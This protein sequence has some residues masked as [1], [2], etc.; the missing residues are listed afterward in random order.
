MGANDGCDAVS[1][2]VTILK[3]RKAGGRA[4]KRHAWYPDI[5]KFKSDDYDAGHSFDHSRAVVTDIASLG[6]LVD[7]IRTDPLC[8]IIRGELK[9]GHGEKGA[10]VARRY[11]KGTN[12]PFED[13]P[14]RWLMAD[15]DNWQIPA[16]LDLVEDT[17][18]IIERAISELLPE[19]FHDCR[20]FWQLS[21]SAGI[22]P[23]LRAHVWY[24]LDRPVPT[25][26]LKAWMEANARGIDQKL[27]NAVQIH[28]CTDPIIVGAP[29]PVP[30]R[31][32]WVQG[33]RD[34]VTMPEMNVGA[35]RTKRS[36]QSYSNASSGG[37]SPSQAAT[38][39]GALAEMGDD[40]GLKG[41]HGPILRAG[42]LY[43]RATPP[44]QR[45]PGALKPKI[46]EAIQA[47][48]KGPQRG[49]DI[50]RYMSDD[51]LD[52]TIVGAFALVPKVDG[53][54][55]CEP[56]HRLPT[57]D[58]EVARARMGDII[59]GFVAKPTRPPML[60]LPSDPVPRRAMV[61]SEVGLGKTQAALEAIADFIKAAKEEGRPHRVIFAIP[62]HILGVAVLARARALGIDA[63]TWHG[64]QYVSPDTGPMCSDYEAVKLAEE[65]SVDAN[66]TVCG[67]ITSDARCRF[68]FTCPYQAQRAPA[69]SA[70]LIVMAHNLLFHRLN[71]EIKGGVGLVVI[72]ESFWQA[73]LDETS[74][75]IQTFA[76]DALSHPCLKR[77][78]EKTQ[79][80]DRTATGDLH[81]YRARVQV[82]FEAS[83]DGYLHLEHTTKAGLSAEDC[84]KAS[85]L[86][87]RR[88][89]D[90]QMWPGMPIHARKSAHAIAAINAQIPRMAALWRA[91]GEALEAGDEVTGRIELEV[92]KHRDGDRRV[93]TVNMRRKFNQSVLD[94]PTL[95]LD[96]TGNVDIVRHFLPDTELLAADRPTLPHVI[97]HQV[98]G[99]LSKTSLHNRAP[100]VSELVDFVRLKTAGEPALVVTNLEFE[101]QF[102]GIPNVSVA[103]FGAMAGRDDW[104]QVRHIFVFGGTQPAPDD[105]RRKAAQLT[106]KAIAEETTTYA[107]RGVLMA[108]GSGVEIRVS[109]YDN[110]DLE[111][112]RTAVADA[113]IVQAV[114][115]GRGANRTAETPLDVWVFGQVIHPY[116]VADI[117]RWN[118]VA[119]NPVER[120]AA[121]K[122]A[123]MGATDAA[124][125]Y[126]DLFPTAEAAR[127]AIHR[128]AEGDFP[129]IP[130]YVSPHKEL[131]GKS[132][133]EILYRPHGRGQNQRTGFAIER[134]VDGLQAWLVG[135]VGPLAH[136]EIVAQPGAEM[137][138]VAPAMDESYLPSLAYPVMN[139]D[140]PFQIVTDLF[141]M[142]YRKRPANDFGR[143][144]PRGDPKLGTRLPANSNG[145]DR[146]ENAI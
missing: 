142:S 110:P 28:Y 86:E 51:Y 89:R 128:A 118:D 1:D 17:D 70:D 141:R 75:T 91:M 6:T 76:A 117:S 30:R 20:A 44:W 7:R 68:F 33:E 64:R 52:S 15:I 50:A 130:L 144:F 24:W 40:E 62:E 48:P 131:S 127:K 73:A 11:K 140:S 111:L 113:A 49:G 135:L 146:A 14:R 136:Y 29:D 107:Q 47:A 27:F 26:A 36:A 101:P 120:M 34:Y 124:K 106:G 37:L 126:P 95:M 9:A 94:C 80:K 41:F 145:A 90:V 88:Q 93:A 58:A 10:P 72:D 32:G 45:N 132:L 137:A 4:T 100:L 54:E 116:P 81:M 67:S 99:G 13:V 114:G 134:H 125:A 25:D 60:G 123:L 133:N 79:I 61:I 63:A 57:E 109:R 108:D 5:G 74:I 56:E 35:L 8:L 3:V 96:G 119:L 65:V 129:D 112:I 115:R 121:R 105:T 59:K 42:M 103:H 43:A 19:P 83:P 78:H 138:P 39:D 31:T 66:K 22:K 38:V 84:F 97:T 85:K 71:D 23:G 122:A 12:P 69:A 92:K 2:T 53:W 77:D 21:A 82:A 143:N 87:W 16:G 46:R 18:I 55:S 98:L 102:E 139:P 104:G